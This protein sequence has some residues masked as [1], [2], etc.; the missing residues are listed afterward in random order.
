[1]LQIA[2]P[3]PL[4]NPKLWMA[5]PAYESPVSQEELAHIQ[6]EID[7]IIGVTR[8]NKSI[9][10]LV[11]NGDTRYW[12]E[13]FGDWDPY[14]EPIGGLQRRPT[15]LYL[16]IFNSH[17]RHVRDTFVPRFLL[18]TRLEPEQ[19]ADRWDASASFYCEERR[20]LVRYQ[21]FGPPKDYYIWFMTIAEHQGFCCQQAAREERSCYGKY[22][23]PRHC[24][25]ELRN[26][27]RSMDAQQLPENHPFDSPDVISEKVRNHMTNNY[28]EQAMN[29][30]LEASSFLLDEAPM[31]IA[32]AGSLERG[33]G[34]ARI[35]SDAVE[36]IGMG[37]DALEKELKQKGAF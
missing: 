15:L 19:Y 29:K 9:A 13:Y 35:R 27:R 5:S 4:D 26:I 25:Q 37:M 34:A 21:P 11:W 23:H 8:D 6:T 31:V 12:K 30:Y 14:G 1:M 33:A 28:A 32:N 24:L 36:H 17:G 2:A 20:R 18:L 16:S 22:A 7:S 3:G 10:K